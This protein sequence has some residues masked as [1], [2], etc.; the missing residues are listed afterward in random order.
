MNNAIHQSF[1]GGQQVWMIGVLLA[2]VLCSSCKRE[3]RKFTVSPPNADTIYATSLTDL[4]AGAT[5][6]P[7][8]ASTTTRPVKN[9]YEEN[10]YAISQGQQLFEKFNCVGCHAHG[11][12]DKGPAL[13]D[14]KWIYGS[15]PDQIFSTI[16]EGRPKGMPSFRGKIQNYQVW[17]LVAYV[18]SLSGLANPNAAPAREDHMRT[19]TYPPNTMPPQRP[20]TAPSSPNAGENSP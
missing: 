3:E 19:L 6:Q 4:H 11:G 13:I 8:T 14:D 12:G 16:I 1:R 9:E 18:R 20:S 5:S 10:A 7:I 2:G 17:E 15:D